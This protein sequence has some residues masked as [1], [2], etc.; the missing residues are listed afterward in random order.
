[1][2]CLRRSSFRG[3]QLRSLSAASAQRPQGRLRCQ[4]ELLRQQQE[5]PPRPTGWQQTQS[6]RMKKFLTLTPEMVSHAAV[7]PV[8]QFYT[9]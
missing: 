7:S 5:W 1:M 9:T 4:R 3:S 2:L 6:L 8:Q